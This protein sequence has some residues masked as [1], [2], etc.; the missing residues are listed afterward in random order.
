[1]AH[2]VQLY[3]SFA[4]DHPREDSAAVALMYETKARISTG[5]TGNT[6][7]EKK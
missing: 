6:G 1:M 2:A 5:I 3:H 4:K 7:S